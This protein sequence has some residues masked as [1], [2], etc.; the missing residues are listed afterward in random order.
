MN[1]VTANGE[2]ASPNHTHT[3]THT[4]AHTSPHHMC[5]LNPRS[6]LKTYP[7][8]IYNGVVHGKSVTHIMFIDGKAAEYAKLNDMAISDCENASPN[9]THTHT[10][11]HPMS[12]I[13][14]RSALTMV[15]ANL[16]HIVIPD[17]EHAS[18]NH[19]HTHLTTPHVP[20]KPA[21][22][23]RHGPCTFE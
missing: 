20:A 9:H 13:N 10:S 5:M 16:N 14:L 19:T 15:P 11:P 22:Y 18:P 12:L 17:G 3:H 2:H 4:H 8:M 7:M 21:E 23:T 1:I 6:T